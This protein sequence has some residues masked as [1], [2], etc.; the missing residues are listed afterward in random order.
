MVKE[1]ESKMRRICCRRD[2]IKT[3]GFGAA[4][5]TLLGCLELLASV[6]EDIDNPPNVIIIL[7]DDQG[8]GDLACHGNPIIKTPNIDRLYEQSVR[9]TDFH[10]SPMC[11]PTRAALL[12]G[13]EAVRT[14]AWR[15]ANGVSFMRADLVTIAD[16]F[17]AHGYRTG[18]FN[19]WHLGDNYPYRPQDR[20]F[21]EVFI[22]LSGGTGQIGD[23]WGNDCFDD[24]YL[25]NGK[26]L[27]VKGYC[28]DVFFD[29]AM[30][31][32]EINKDR[33]F[34]MY[35]P[36]TSPH[37]PWNVPVKYVKPYQ[38]KGIS[39]ALAHR[40]GMI[41]NVDENIGRLTAYLKKLS[42]EDNTILIFLSDN[43]SGLASVGSVKK[44][45]KPFN[46]GMRG[47]KGSVYDGGH[48]VPFFIRFPSAGITGGKDI[49]NLTAHIDVLLTLIDLC[50]LKKPGELKFDGLSMAKLLKGQQRKWPE[51]TFFV[52][53]WA[54]QFPTKWGGRVTLG[55]DLEGVPSGKQGVVI[56]GKWR[57]VNNSELYDIKIDPAQKNNIAK[58]Y[59][60]IVEKLRKAYDKWWAD[61]RQDFKLSH[62]IIGSDNDNPTTMTAMDWHDGFLASQSQ[63]RQGTEINGYWLV[64]V[65]RV[66]TYQFQLR[67]WP[68]EV[69]KS[70]T[71]ALPP[72]ATTPGVYHNYHTESGQPLSLNHARL[73]IAD[74]DLTKPIPEDAVSVTFETQLKA[75]KTRLQTWFSDDKTGKSRGAYYV[76]VKRLP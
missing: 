14:G 28:T 33:P 31:F 46:A 6:S 52:H 71:A 41:T 12:T 75:G 32:I 60:N 27:E 62:I 22:N 64:K 47:G 29:A 18:I 2:L 1:K 5:I 40:F 9:L 55:E 48:R 17:S 3:A 56:N 53:R 68:K 72:I 66:G 73:K 65:D 36:T 7:T 24:T 15:P 23:N 19:K 21:Q 37:G 76:Y 58:D 4:V 61:V 49:D 50:G 67:R 59:P 69:N 63:V 43:G 10:V 39:A 34:F 57:F 44:Y 8:Y 38:E 16:V 26:P 54:G 25:H 45:G 42:L 51:R 35:L 70:I 30:R 74:V 13:R 11:S 20:G